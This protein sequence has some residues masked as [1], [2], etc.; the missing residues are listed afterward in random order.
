MPWFIEIGREAE[1]VGVLDEPAID[2]GLGLEG[3]IAVFGADGFA[4]D[5][6]VEGAACEV[7]AVFGETRPAGVGRLLA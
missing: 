5:V 2:F 1:F 6:E 4:A 3:A 7:R